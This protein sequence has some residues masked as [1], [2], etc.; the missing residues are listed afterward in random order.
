MDRVV[1]NPHLSFL[2]DSY[3]LM[4]VFYICTRLDFS[5]EKDGSKCG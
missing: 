2:L 5:L 3:N 4:Q 1:L